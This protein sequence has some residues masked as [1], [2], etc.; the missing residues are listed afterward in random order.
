MI[1]RRYFRFFRF[2]LHVAIS[3]FFGFAAILSQRPEYWSAHWFRGLINVLNVHIYRSGDTSSTPALVAGN[4]Q[5]WLDIAVLVSLKP[6]IFVSKAEVASWPLL[7]WLAKSGDTLFI[8][9]GAHGS[10]EVNQGI[11]ARLQQGRCVVIFP[12]STTTAGPGVRRFQPRLFAGAIE[13]SCPVLPFALR[14]RQSCAPYVGEQS[15]IGN[16][17]AILG[18]T[19]IDVEVCF[20]PPLEAGQRRDAIAQQTQNWVERTLLQAPCWQ[21]SESQ[22]Q[23]QTLL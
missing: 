6:V 10:Q 1:L 23:E 5:S 16:L 2:V 22:E 8:R 21:P 15:L 11:S 7:G 3:P 19:N 12:E 4:H 20:G 9:R 18:E 17:W 13:Q 14:Y